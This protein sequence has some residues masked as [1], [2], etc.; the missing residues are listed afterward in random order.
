MR[1]SGEWATFVGVSLYGRAMTSPRSSLVVLGALALGG[2]LILAGCSSSDSSSSPSPSDSASSSASS[3]TTQASGDCS[4]EIINTKLFSADGGAT[5]ADCVEVDGQW[6]AGGDWG[7]TAAG[8]SGTYVA[9][10]DPSTKEWMEWDE[11]CS[12]VPSELQQYCVAPSDSP[13]A[14][15]K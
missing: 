14:T 12:E 4:L 2:G 3:T 15:K 9:F 8:A 7:T 10:V 11:A 5:S 1:P 13:T 6:W